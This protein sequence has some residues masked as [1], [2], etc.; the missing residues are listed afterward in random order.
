MKK[1]FLC[2]VSK[3]RV[4]PINSY[5][6]TFKCGNIFAGICTLVISLWPV[7]QTPTSNR[8]K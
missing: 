4:G 8:P 6:F 1:L 5:H 7:H 2:S 3:P